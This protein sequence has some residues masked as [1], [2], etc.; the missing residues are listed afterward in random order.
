MFEN[1]YHTG[2]RAL[3]MLLVFAMMFAML[4]D[5]APNWFTAVAEEASEDSGSSSSGESS[6]GGESSSH[7]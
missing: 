1:H 3:A 7:S 4:G 5:Y 6:S 2:K